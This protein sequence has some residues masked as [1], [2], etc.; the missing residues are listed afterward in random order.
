MRGEAPEEED[1][2]EQPVIEKVTSP[3][4]SV[5]APQLGPKG[6]GRTERSGE[7]LTPVT[8]VHVRVVGSIRS[9]AFSDGASLK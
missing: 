6:D 5:S 3:P 2:R 1:Q 7:E 4:P 8:R 9:H